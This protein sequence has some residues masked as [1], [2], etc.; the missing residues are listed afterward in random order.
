MTSLRTRTSFGRVAALV[1]TLLAMPLAGCATA[2]RE[3]TAA[4]D[5]ANDPLE[6][7]NRTVYG[8]NQIADFLIINP[9]AEIYR[10]VL[11]DPVERSVRNFL[12]NL[13][14]PLVLANQLLQ[15]DWEGA[16]NA[17]SRFVINTV[18]GV[19]GLFDVADGM[20]YPYQ[21][22]DF[23]QT[24]GV[25]GLPE[26]AYLVL[27]ILGPSSLRDATGIGVEWFSDPVNILAENNGYGWVPITRGATTGL[28][29]R[30]EYRGVIDDVRRNSIDP[31]AQFRSLYRQRRASEIRDGRSAPGG[32]TEFPEFEDTPA[33]PAR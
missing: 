21:H 22:E 3:T 30:N 10:T 33:T 1:L 29:A 15:G 11:P 18:G 5:D 8:F 20:G 27:P 12:R 28:D 32:T 17:G 31:Y 25:W 6:G 16:K 14:S 9:A 2:G 26:G 13:S 19:G 24:L 23:G 4:A 7:L